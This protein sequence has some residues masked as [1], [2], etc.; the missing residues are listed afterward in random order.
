MHWWRHGFARY[1]GMNLKGTKNRR[2]LMTANMTAW[3]SRG[4]VAIVTTEVIPTMIAKTLPEPL[5]E[6]GKMARLPIAKSSLYELSKR[7]CRSWY[8]SNCRQNYPD[9]LGAMMYEYDNAVRDEPEGVEGHRIQ[10]SALLAH[11][12]WWY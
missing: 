3:K 9:F 1:A 4:F 11:Y 2:S 12:F 5:S 10:L 7:E 6:R 8:R